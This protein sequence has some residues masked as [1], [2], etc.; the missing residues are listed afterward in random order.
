MAVAPL[1]LALALDSESQAFF[2]GQRRAHFPPERNHLAA[3]LTLFH[4]LPGI[5]AAAIEATLAT[6]AAR[7]PLLDLPVRG[8]QFLG[9]G[10]AYVLESTELLDLHRRLQQTW[11]PWL[12]PQD[13]QP[14]RLHVTVQNKAEPAVARALFAR[15]EAEFVPFLAV[16]LGLQLWTYRGGPWEARASWGFGG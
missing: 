5:E 16:G 12:T 10:V 6:E 11:H 4:A 9:R 15:L 2:D 8:V 14:R 7:Q 1:I 3:H 13:R